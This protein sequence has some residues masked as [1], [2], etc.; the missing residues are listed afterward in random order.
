[1]TLTACASYNCNKGFILPSK[2]VTLKMDL[3]QKKELVKHAEDFKND[4]PTT[5]FI[6]L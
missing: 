4:C 3:D 1:M 2:E 5:K 6:N